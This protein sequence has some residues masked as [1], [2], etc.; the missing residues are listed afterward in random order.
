[1]S[2]DLTKK[3]SEPIGG[4]ACPVCKNKGK[5]NFYNYSPISAF[6]KTVVCDICG[7]AFSVLKIDTET[8][9][10]VGGICCGRWK[11]DV[12]HSYIEGNET[13]NEGEPYFVPLP[14][15]VNFGEK[16]DLV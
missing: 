16:V 10:V 5:L 13:Y 15:P 2:L 8:N 11:R 7:T 4:V 12:F 3:Y 14:K 9:Q 1:M 6:T